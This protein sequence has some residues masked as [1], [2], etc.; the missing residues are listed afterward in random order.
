MTC[1]RCG[2]CC[3][4][5]KITGQ[6][7][8]KIYR[9]AADLPISLL[10]ELG[11]I[12]V[13]WAGKCREH[14]KKV[15]ESV[16]EFQYTDGKE[17]GVLRIKGEFYMCDI[18]D[19]EFRPSFCSNERISVKSKEVL[20]EKLNSGAELPRCAVVEVLGIDYLAQMKGVRSVKRIVE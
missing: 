9:S 5:V 19:R 20:E 11:D 1:Y 3:N 12:G 14:L 18:Y 7:T 13:P 8:H 16:M 10:Q 4:N 6:G 15:P 2:Y 17:S